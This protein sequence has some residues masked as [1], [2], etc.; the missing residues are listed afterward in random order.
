M[1]DGV[2]RLFDALATDYLQHAALEHEVASRLFGRLMHQRR[3]PARIADLGAGPGNETSE[4]KKRYRKAEVIALDISLS[5]CRLARRQSGRWL[6]VRPVCANFSS[7]PLAN[8]SVDLIFSNLALQWSP[9][10]RGLTSELRRVLR[11]DG[12]LVFSTVGPNSLPELKTACAAVRGL[13]AAPTLPDMH[14]L[15]DALLAAGFSQPVVDSESITMEYR[16]LDLLLRDLAATGP[17]AQ[18]G[19]SGLSGEAKNGIFRAYEAFR[20]N[21]VYPATWEILYGAGFGPGEGQAIKSPKGDTAAFSV[22]HLRK[23]LRRG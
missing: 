17:S 11:P 4:L 21:G 2:A 10:F 13:P 5:M 23:S 1:G 3:T 19:T 9:D 6:P 22:E 14:D 16:E 15:G 12:L 20:R 18:F 8:G 7:L